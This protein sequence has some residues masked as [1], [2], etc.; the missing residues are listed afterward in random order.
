MKLI[1][2]PLARAILARTFMSC[3]LSDD[4]TPP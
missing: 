2:N 4:A 1:N 3:L